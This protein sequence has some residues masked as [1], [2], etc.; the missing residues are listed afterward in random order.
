[1]GNYVCPKTGVTLTLR[2]PR[3]RSAPKEPTSAPAISADVPVP[4]GL[5]IKTRAA[6]SAPDLLPWQQQIRAIFKH[7][8]V[9]HFKMIHGARNWKNTKLPETKEDWML[10]DGT[11]EDVLYNRLRAYEQDGFNVY[12]CIATFDYEK[13]H[14]ILNAEY[15]D[16]AKM[17]KRRVA[18]NIAFVNGEHVIR[19]VGIECDD[20]GEASLVKI[21]EAVAAGT[22]PTPTL[23][24]QSSTP[25][26][27]R[28]GVAKY[29]FWWAVEGFTLAQQEAMNRTLQQA[30]G[31][32]AAATDSVRVL[33]LAGFVNNKPK[34]YPHK[35]VVT[36]VESSEGRYTIDQFKLPI[37]E[38]AP[39]AERPKASSFVIEG[40]TNQLEENAEKANYDLGKQ[41]AWQGIGFQFEPA[42]C[43]NA[44]AHTEG[45]RG[46][47]AIRVMA[48]GARDA[49]CFHR[50]C[51]EDKPEEGSTKIDWQWFKSYLDERAGEPLDWSNN[52]TVIMPEKTEKPA[53]SKSDQ[54]ATA[55]PRGVMKQLESSAIVFKYP[56]VEGTPF[57]FVVGPA[58]A[59]PEGWCPRG[60]VHLIGGPSGASKTTFMVDLLEAQAKRESYL[61]HSTYGLPYLIIMA[62]RGTFA[63]LRTANRMRFDPEAIP[64]GFMPSVTGAAA[65]REILREIEKRDVLP[66]VVFVEGA[67]MLA[68]NASKMEM[69]VPFVDGLQKIAAHYHIA[70][71][72]SVGSPKMRKG[73]GYVSKRDGIFGTVAWSRKTETIMVLQYIEGD[74][75]DARRT[76]SVLLRNGPSEK[77]DMKLENGRLMQVFK[78]STKIVSRPYMLWFRTQTSWFTAEDAKE[79]LKV[80]RA[81]A[82]RYV[83]HAYTKGYLKMKKGP[84]GGAKQYKWNDSQKNPENVQNDAKN[85]AE[86]AESARAEA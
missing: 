9:L 23:V 36:I 49:S 73:E 15:A 28:D 40:V 8:D 37:V 32:D 72:C 35:P 29:H 74:D 69:V 77:Y 4:A 50:H 75:M 51:K 12:L 10:F 2:T 30:F 21:R 18:E 63:H 6:K 27:G 17:P 68:E 84:S 14:G 61:S 11:D 82:D 1:M 52:W 55:D 45:G 53:T 46:G 13:I 39:Q 59:C 48:S 66:A 56:K 80:S 7:G 57:D 5:T 54:T 24:I 64:I 65:L 20:D 86:P 44:D 25:E 19:A 33:R 47:F 16:G 41:T 43:P 70:I 76:L 67:D 60:D 83:A 31:G 85:D 62:D 26:P 3:E 58:F 79:G 22:I 42:E 81:T 71:I 38:E 34:K 78:D